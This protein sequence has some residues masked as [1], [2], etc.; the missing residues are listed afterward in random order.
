MER[1]AAAVRPLGL[2]AARLERLKTAV[3]EATLNAMEHGNR[4]CPGRPVTIRV[5][6]SDD[7]LCVTVIDE[8]GER[9]R[10]ERVEPSLEAK[11]AGQQS[12]R[13]WGLFLIEH[14][15]D[16]VSD[17]CVGMLHSVHLRLRL[18]PTDQPPG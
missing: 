15:V 11:L 8:G 14:M 9:P 13:G 16:D 4:F 5:A 17:E 10:H 3:S 18:R 12:P 1:V 2:A 7:E 6:A